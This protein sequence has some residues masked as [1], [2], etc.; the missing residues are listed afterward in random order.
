MPLASCVPKLT[1]STHDRDI[2]A[3]TGKGASVDEDIND[4]VTATAGI[5]SRR[6]DTVSVCGQGD[7]GESHGIKGQTFDLAIIDIEVQYPT[8]Q[9]GYFS[10]FLV[11]SSSLPCFPARLRTPKLYDFA[12]ESARD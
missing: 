9:P 8:A 12:T 5:T 3:Q 1:R 6:Q 2:D 10:T 7:C 4:H 11:P